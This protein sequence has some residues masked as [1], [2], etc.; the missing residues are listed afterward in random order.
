LTQEYIT[1]NAGRDDNLHFLLSFF[2]GA[3]V[4][5]E[6]SRTYSLTDNIGGVRKTDYASL[7]VLADGY[8][9]KRTWARAQVTRRFDIDTQG[10][11]LPGNIYMISARSNLRRGIDLRAEMIANERVHDTP[12]VDR[13]QTSSLFDL[14]LV[15][16]RSTLITPHVQ[17]AKYSDQLSFVGNDR[18]MVGVTVT[19]VPVFPRMSMG[20]D[21]NRNTITIGNRRVDTAGAINLSTSLRSR[22]TFNISYGIRNTDRYGPGT[23]VVVSKSRA[24][25]LHAQAQV[26]LTRRGSLSINYTGVNQSPEP[27]TNQFAVTYRQDF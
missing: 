9:H 25:T 23:N 27:D 24:H 6:V 20:L 14:Y 3:H 17:F 10:G 2:E 4:R 16:W 1:E 15:P 11:V 21:F 8:L 12:F 5:P 7:Q 13:F 26:W 19:Y 18:A 22:S